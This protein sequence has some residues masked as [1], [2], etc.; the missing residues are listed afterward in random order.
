LGHALEADLERLGRLVE[1]LPEG[2]RV[3]LTEAMGEHGHLLP[4][5]LAIGHADT[6]LLTVG[7][8]A[9]RVVEGWNR[10]ATDQIGLLERVLA[11]AKDQTHDPLHAGH[12]VEEVPLALVG[13]G[14]LDDAAVVPVGGAEA[15]AFVDL[16]D[17]PAQDA[18]FPATGLALV[19]DAVDG[20]PLG[21]V[22]LPG[23]ARILP[24]RLDGEI[25]GLSAFR[26]F[27]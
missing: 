17:H 20:V 21:S 1:E 5:A 13:G 16:V 6:L 12:A 25:A 11:D 18:A 2:R 15:A 9:G 3:D 10:Q 27:G 4:R 26:G 7:L 14:D 22:R 19:A 24:D 23:H 8:D